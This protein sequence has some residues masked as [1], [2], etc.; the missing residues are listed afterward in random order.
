MAKKNYWFS[1]KKGSGI[2][3]YG[4]GF[5]PLN[6]QGCVAYLILLGLIILVGVYFDI[7]HTTLIPGLGFVGSVII[8]LILFRIIARKRTKIEK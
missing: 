8:L 1:V 6:W 4:I 2:R 7:L 5:I 3:D